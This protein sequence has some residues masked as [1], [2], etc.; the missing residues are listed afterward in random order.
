[1][2]IWIFHLDQWHSFVK[3]DK[4]RGFVNLLKSRILP[5]SFTCNILRALFILTKYL[6]YYP[7]CL[8]SLL[9][10]VTGSCTSIFFGEVAVACRH[11]KWCLLLH[12][13]LWVGRCFFGWWWWKRWLLSLLQIIVSWNV[14]AC[15]WQ[16]MVKCALGQPVSI[17]AMTRPTQLVKTLTNLARS[18]PLNTSRRVVTVMLS[19]FCFA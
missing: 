5:C 13:K 9:A 1:M 15:C 6:L 2:Y 10:H 12:L 4:L 17:L 16:V 19:S 14:D 8:R 7:F 18:V 11:R 3:G